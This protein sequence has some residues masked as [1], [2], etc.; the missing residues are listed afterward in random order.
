MPQVEIFADLGGRP[1]NL[2]PHTFIKITHPDGTETGYG[3]SSINN[4]PVGLGQVTDNT[5]HE[6]DISSGKI[7]ITNDQYAA[8]MNYISESDTTW[9]IYDLAT[10]RTCTTWVVSALSSAGIPGVLAPNPNFRNI[11]YNVAFNPYVQGAGFWISNKINDAAGTNFTDAQLITPRRD[12]LTL[13][14]DGDGIETVPASSTNPILFDHD[15]DGVMTGTGWV[16][17]D[18]GFLVLDR[19][20]NGTIDNG[21]ELFGDATPL[22]AGGTAADGFAALRQVDRK[23]TV[24]VRNINPRGTA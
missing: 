5:Y 11:L 15:G 12:P 4:L 8:L 10:G 7:G 20:S 21:A 19:N 13:D 23:N 14:L 24:I 3:F 1:G 6:A 17:P 16:S 9:P 18:D 22:Y 2:L